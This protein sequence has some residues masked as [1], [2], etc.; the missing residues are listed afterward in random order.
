MLWRGYSS[1]GR[2]ATGHDYKLAQLRAALRMLKIALDL[3]SPQMA[4]GAGTAFVTNFHSCTE[5]R[6]S[7]EGKSGK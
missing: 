5:N 3:N 4:P 1:A 7:N 2:I 6:L